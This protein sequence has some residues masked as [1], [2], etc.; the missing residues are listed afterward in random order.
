MTAHRTLLGL[1][2]LG[3]ASLVHAQ[4]P[5]RVLSFPGGA[6]LPLWVAED[7]GLFAHEQLAVK[8]S[9]TPNS[10]VLVQSLI[11]N[12]EDIAMA[13]FDNVVAY[14]EGQ[15]EVQLSTAPDLFA[16][17]GTSR[18]TIR[19][20]VSPDVRGY[21]DLRG[22][23]LAVD[24]LATGYSLVLQKLLQLGGLEEGDYRLE[25][26][27]A[28]ATRAQALME[29]KFAGTILTTPLEIAPESRG[30]RRLANAVDV[31]G[32]YQTIV[33]MARRSWARDNG[34]ALVHFIRASTE[35]IDW[36]YDPKNRAEAVQIYRQH[37][38]NVP[39]DAAQLHV[40]ALLGER[41][42]FTRGGALDFEGMM[43]VLRIRSEFGLPRKTLTDPARYID[44]RY[45]KAARGR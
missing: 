3:L 27:G 42:G 12:E 1:A 21:G 22:K 39:E 44:E 10:V 19:L 15:G 34:V 2:A 17:V 43:T 26:V 30:Y 40:N 32:P 5:L 13:A 8:V 38:P 4:T 33:G 29:N 20:V 14:Q 16:F 41:D 45:L 35:A 23:S 6:N 9:S 28:T 37:L 25:S 31:L 11:K 36:L 18:G 24:A 7:K